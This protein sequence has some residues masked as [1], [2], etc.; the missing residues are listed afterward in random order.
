MLL[1]RDIELACD[2]KVI[3]ELGRAE[4]AAYSQTL[5][6]C[7]AHR[8]LAAC[9]VAFG[10]TDVKTRVKAVLNYKKPAFWIILAAVLGCLVLVVCFAAN[11]VGGKKSEPTPPPT[12][13]M[14]ST[15][16]EDAGSSAFETNEYLPLYQ[17]VLD[18]YSAALTTAN[19]EEMGDTISFRTPRQ[20][21]PAKTIPFGRNPK[22][23]WTPRLCYTC[24]MSPRPMSR[25]WR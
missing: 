11:P 9:P 3:R 25:T 12:N 24:S 14:P 23:P 7:S 15:M 4:R 1:C 21:T 8:I 20:R 17:S 18:M 10:E 6:N 5:L 22:S 19:V 13:E 16:P 2:E